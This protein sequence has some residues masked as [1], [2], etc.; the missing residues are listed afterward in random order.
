MK[1]FIKLRNLINYFTYLIIDFFL[2][3]E[4]KINLNTLL[5]IRLDA[6]G[7][8]LL[9]RNYLSVIRTSKKYKNLLNAI[10][11]TLHHWPELDRR[12]FIMTHYR[13]KS[14]EAVAGSLNLEEK[15]IDIILKHCDRQLHTA[16]RDYKAGNRSDLNISGLAACG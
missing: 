16:L 12:V 8:Y 3:S 15:E 6:I 13:G 2:P 7:D 10:A 14:R 1:Y 5:I 9:F 11:S 4:Q